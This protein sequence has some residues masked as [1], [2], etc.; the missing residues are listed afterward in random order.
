MLVQIQF[1]EFL[2][3]TRYLSVIYKINFIK[4]LQSN[5]HYNIQTNIELWSHAVTNI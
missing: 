5:K 1:S 3:W 4:V 2:L